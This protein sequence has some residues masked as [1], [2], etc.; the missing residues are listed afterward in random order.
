M[1]LPIF[2]LTFLTVMLSFLTSGLE[3]IL[4]SSGDHNL[5]PLW[6]HLLF[7]VF[8][9]LLTGKIIFRKVKFF[10]ISVYR[11]LIRFNRLFGSIP[12]S[13]HNDLDLNDLQEKV[14]KN[15]ND[16]LKDS[17]SELDCS[18]KSYT[19]VVKNSGISYILR[20]SVER[21]LTI[22]GTGDR[23]V[24]YEVYIPQT[25]VTEM[26]N[27]FDKVKEEK[28]CKSELKSRKLIEDLL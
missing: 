15:W 1:K 8:T 26:S 5:L 6:T 10:R 18:L 2:I 25:K 16:L 28:L 23:N 3:N 11:N 19:R 12:M 24:F 14:I 22:I 20:S 9:L 21:P 7:W 17:K 27:T 13:F 4:L